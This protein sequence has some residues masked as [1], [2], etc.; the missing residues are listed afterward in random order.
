MSLLIKAR[1]VDSIQSASTVTLYRLR[2]ASLFGFAGNS[3]QRYLQVKTQS[4]EAER[5]LLRHLSIT[6]T[7]PDRK[8]AFDGF[9]NSKNTDLKK[10][11][12][13]FTFID[14][15]SWIKEKGK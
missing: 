9:L 14:I 2:L 10:I 4:S 7:M 8:P 6:Y 12:M 11:R 5:L 13:A 15:V 3:M 1:L